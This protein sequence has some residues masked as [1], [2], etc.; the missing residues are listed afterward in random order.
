MSEAQPGN[1]FT[2]LLC[3]FR[4]GASQSE[5]SKALET[6]VGAVRETGR[7]G[8]LRYTLTIKPAAHGNEA[9]AIADNI[10]LDAPRQERDQSIFY[11]TTENRLQR[12]NP[13]QMR[14]ELREV[15]RAIDVEVRDVP[16]Q[17]VEVRAPEPVAETFEEIVNGIGS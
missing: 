10:E 12:D 1:A 14:L 17:R 16:A 9:L 6:L 4:E 7:K 2:R 5:L 3:E 11:A 8:K 15:A 13:K